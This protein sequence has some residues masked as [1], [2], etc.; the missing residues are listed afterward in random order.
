MIVTKKLCEGKRNEPIASLTELGWVIHGAITNS[1]DS[2]SQQ[3]V[4]HLH[5]HEATTKRAA[6]EEC[7]RL[8]S[9]QVGLPWKTDNFVMPPS[10]EMAMRRLENVE[11][12]IKKAPEYRGSYSAQIKILLDKGYAEKCSGNEGEDPRA[13]WLPHFA[14][15]NPNKPGKIRLVFDAAAASHGMSLQ[16]IRNENARQPPYIAHQVTEIAELTKIDD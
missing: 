16:W 5:H 14:V 12:K 13:W 2:D 4:L 11:K 1:S 8:L 9:Y 10:Y 6:D 7:Q 3:R 15:T